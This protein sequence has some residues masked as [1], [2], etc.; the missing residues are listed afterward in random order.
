MIDTRAIGQELQDQLQAA[1][2]KGQQRVTTTARTVAA[3]A[4]MIRPQLPNLPRP[5]PGTLRSALPTP[6]Q[7]RSAMPTPEQIR[8]AMPTPEQIRSAL[9]V[10]A[11]LIE[12]APAFAAKLPGAQRLTAG[13]HELIG[14][15]RA[16]QHRV[17][18]QVREATAPLAKRAG[19]AELRWA[20]GHAVH[21]GTVRH[22]TE[23]G[24]PQVA[25]HEAKQAAQPTP[26]PARKPARKPT[27]KATAKP[28]AK[29]GPRPKPTSK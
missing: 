12:Q 25:E 29:G 16:V 27:A 6:E 1:A 13:T 28:A 15:M 8:S 10:P 7:I 17:L 14:Q 21:G 11:Q 5:T 26:K 4:R 19:F 23:N 2:R 20:N 24:S 9:A 18:D 3:T 22:T